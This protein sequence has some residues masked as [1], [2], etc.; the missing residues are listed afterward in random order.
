MII[1]VSYNA[2]Y[3]KLREVKKAHFPDFCRL[4]LGWLIFW[5][6]LTV[7]RILHFL[8]YFIVLFVSRLQILPVLCAAVSVR[9]RFICD[10]LCSCKHLCACFITFHAA[11]YNL[12]FSAMVVHLLL[13][14]HYFA[15]FYQ[16]VSMDAPICM[17]ADCL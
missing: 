5:L 4:S 11:F 3:T 17:D 16:I 12:Q 8:S 6:G 14:R 13:R 7:L 2:R 9:L 1:V 10:S 15:R